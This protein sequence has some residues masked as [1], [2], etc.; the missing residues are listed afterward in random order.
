MEHKIGRSVSLYSYQQE[1]HEGKLDL[2]GCIREVAKTGATGIELLAEQ[3]V[4]EF[5]VITPEFKEKWFGWMKQYNT[6]PTCYDAFLE[7]KIYDN[8]TLTLREQIA[9]ME[10]D[11]KIAHEL[12]FQTL[13]TLVATPMNVIEGSLACAKEHD[14]K[15]C[16]EVHSPFSLNSGWSDGYMEMIL[17]TQTKHFGFMPDWGIFCKHI[18]DELRNQAFRF[19]ATT[20]GVK[21]VD[22]FFHERISKGI[23]KIKYDLNLGKAHQDYMKANGFPKVMEALEKINASKADIKYAMSSFEYTWCD[24]KDILDNIDYIYHTHAKCYNLTKDCIDPVIPID[25]VVAAYKKAGYKGYLSTEYEGNRML[26]D[27]LEVD[28]IEQVRRHQVALQR[29]IETA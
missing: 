4:D 8:R 24:T 1:Y 28:S 23:E 29:A 3:M 9:M 7:N 19:G 6:E 16:I 22:D 14:I 2:E 20:E 27:A 15:V 10:R 5:P 12:G 25:E 26:N 17:R 11:I 21:I 18:P 13:R